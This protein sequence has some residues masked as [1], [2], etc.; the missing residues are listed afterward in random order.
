MIVELSKT[1]SPQNLV[2]LVIDRC[3]MKC[4]I[5]VM[6]RKVVIVCHIQRSTDC[7]KA[8]PFIF[9]YSCYFLLFIKKL[10]DFFPSLNTVLAKHLKHFSGESEI[11][12]ETFWRVDWFQFLKEEAVELTK[13]PHVCNYGS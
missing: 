1:Q 8:A 4:E 6:E 5:T 13:V 9:M 7:H 3:Q 12:C 2:L 10:V 11:F